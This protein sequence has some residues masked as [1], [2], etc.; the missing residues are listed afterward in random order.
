MKFIFLHLKIV[1]ILNIR[2]WILN[3]RKWVLNIRKW[4]SNIRKWIS[5]IR[6]WI[7]NIR[8][9]ISNIR[10]YRFLSTLACHTLL[11]LQ[12]MSGWTLR[13]GSDSPLPPLPSVPFLH[14]SPLFLLPPLFSLRDPPN[15]PPVISPFS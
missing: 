5:N 14:F 13:G 1:R 8:K 9:W 15:P 6:K 4:I 10:K 7:S 3:I 12:V 11:P 2:K